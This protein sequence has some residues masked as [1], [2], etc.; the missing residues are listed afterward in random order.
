MKCCEL[1]TYVCSHT[2]RSVCSHEIEDRSCVREL[3]RNNLCETGQKILND[4]MCYLCVPLTK[5]RDISL[6]ETIE[7]Y[8][9]YKTFSPTSCH[10]PTLLTQDS[11]F[12]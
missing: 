1:F 9:R 7:S 10:V 8:V 6:V 4:V 2:T 11:F 3:R 5:E 12:S